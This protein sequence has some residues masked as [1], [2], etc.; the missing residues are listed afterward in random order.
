MRLDLIPELVDAIPVTDV[1]LRVLAKIF[2][3][4]SVD[5][6]VRYKVTIWRLREE[7][8]QFFSEQNIL[9]KLLTIDAPL[10]ATR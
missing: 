10:P 5:E 6:L 2:A 7:Y 1:A 3:I 9:L 4:C 8:K